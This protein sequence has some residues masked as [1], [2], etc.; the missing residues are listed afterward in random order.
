MPRTRRV[1]ARSEKVPATTAARANLKATRPVAS[2]IRL[3]PFRIVVMRAGTRRRSVTALTATA[4]VGETMAPRA[5]AIASGRPGT[6]QCAT[7]PTASVVKVTRPTQGG[8]SGAS[9]WRAPAAASASRRRRGAAAGSRGRRS[10]GRARTPGTAGRRAAADPADQVRDELGPGQPAGDDAERVTIR[11]RRR[12]ACSKAVMVRS[13]GGSRPVRSGCLRPALLAL[14]VPGDPDADL[15]EEVEGDR[16]RDL[17]HDLGRRQ[18][19][20]Q[21]ERQDGDVAAVLRQRARG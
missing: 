6:S 18:D 21:D 20:A 13:A 3:S 16:H 11:R 14:P 5:N 7:R 17:R 9:P 10:R 4:S 15:V 1:M 12:S 19:G 2:F 8:G